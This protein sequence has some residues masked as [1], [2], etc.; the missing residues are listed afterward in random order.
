[1]GIC[2]P[3]CCLP[4][5][6]YSFHIL[7]PDVKSRQAPVTTRIL[8]SPAFRYLSERNKMALRVGMKRSRD[9]RTNTYPSSD[10]RNDDVCAMMVDDV[11]MLDDSGIDADKDDDDDEMHS[12]S[13]S[14]G[15]QP[16]RKRAMV[17]KANIQF[18]KKIPPLR[19]YQRGRFGRRG[20]VDGGT[21]E[22]EMGI[23]ALEESMG[24][25][26][27]FTPR[28]AVSSSRAATV[29]PA[30]L[31]INQRSQ[32]NPHQ[33]R[34]RESPFQ[35]QYQYQNRYSNSN[36]NTS[37]AFASRTTPLESIHSRYFRGVA[38]TAS[39]SSVKDDE[40]RPATKDAGYW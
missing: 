31:P 39:V 38:S 1:M 36:R 22:S 35:T 11:D 17:I 10:T 25:S 21:P 40:S 6:H 12:N 23:H 37:I 29:A 16:R 8:E 7:S 4:S 2:F 3:V 14:N 32:Q 19:T 24:E 34:Q 9:A 5:A 30:P 33:N 13:D 28:Q 18:L 15:E 20:G 27:F 26:S